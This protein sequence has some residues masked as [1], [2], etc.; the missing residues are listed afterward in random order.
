MRQE[1]ETLLA[2]SDDVRSNFLQSSAS[3]L[4]LAS[5]TKLGEYE[6][7][8]LLGSGGMGEVYR[9]RDSRLGRD[10]AIKVLPASLSADSE[11]LRRFEQEARA[12]AALNHPNILA[13]FQMG[14]YEG[15][16]YLVSELLEGE[17]LREQIKRGR[18]SVRKSID[19]GVQIT[20][21]LAAAHEKGIVHRDLK[22]EN[23]FVTRDGHVKI[24]DFGLAKLTQPQ[25]SSENSAPTFTEGTE[26][27]VVM[28]TVGYMSPEQVRGQKADHRADIFAF[29]AILYEML[30]G[31]RA[32]QRPTSPETM[33]AIL[34]EDPPG[35]SQVTANIAPALQRVVH[36]C[37]EKN[38]EQRFQS[39]SDLAFALDALS[40]TSSNPAALS[41]RQSRKISKLWPVAAVLAIAAV[42]V[43]VLRF[44]ILPHPEPKRELVERQLTANPPENTVNSAAISRDGKYLA[45]T[46][47]SKKLNLLAI[48]GGELR[49][50]PLPALYSV[51]DWFP[52]GAHLLLEGGDLWKMSTWDSS[53]RKLWTG[54][55]W[56]ATVSP[57][58]SHI[59]FIKGQGGELWLMGADGEEPHKILALPAQA[60]LLAI[61]WSPTGQRLA[62]LRG[63]DAEGV[64]NGAIETCD[65]SGG[66][67][68]AV[69][70][71]SDLLNDD[72]EASLAWLPDGRIIYSK[73]SASAESDLW[74]VR[75]EPAGGRVTGGSTRV[76][77]WKNFA[78][79][80]PQASADGKRLIAARVRVAS[81]VYIADLAT[82]NKEFTTRRFTLDDWYNWATDWTNDSKAILFTSQ[83]N[84]RWAIYEQRLDSHSPETLIAGPESYLNPRLSAQG[85]VVYTARSASSTTNYRLMSTPEHGGARSTLMTGLYTYACATS[86]S[87]SCVVAV[88]KGQDLIFSHL[89]PVRGKGEEI[90]RISGYKTDPRWD[91]SP[92]GSKIA[93]VDPVEQKG[94]VR[95]L[96]VADRKVAV[97]TV[98]DWKWNFLSLIEWAADG[99]TLF[100]E[101]QNTSSVAL[102]SIDP[103]G[104]P[105]ILQEMPAGSAWIG[106]IV[107]S[108]DGRFLALTKRTYL[109]DVMLLENF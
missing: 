92:D 67:P 52:D 50:L 20:R 59:A 35:I 9:A 87:S 34:N 11:R 106:G 102:I 103:N 74:A 57:D 101:A 44:R 55:A 13:V 17:T 97:L 73:R 41:N 84:G 3:R 8:S 10:V 105:K 45:Y 60:F 1:V 99:K 27:G 42:G 58:G 90:A 53:L 77:G 70:S 62:Y 69:L 16:P 96:S 7:K 85:D 107:P 28:G 89:D 31:K 66:T 18:L 83:R 54:H 98:R 25:P 21:G 72:A 12:A 39:A 26:A 63:K 49:Q 82:G 32:F 5:G 93:I 109:E 38:Q 15:A 94:E 79:M 104:N 37:L 95:M 36:R 33:T 30:A 23:L 4:T 43:L 22:P 51:F 24:L 75:A 29:G 40:E 19:H 48:D 80:D 14:T 47:F 91:L 71:G 2:S 78:A 86:P 76:G 46:D 100:A 68:T 65:L 88:L 108:P 81:G 6:V 64:G 61:A 56:K